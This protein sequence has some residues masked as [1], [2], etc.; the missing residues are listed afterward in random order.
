MADKIII[1]RTEFPDSI[2]IGTPGKFGNIKVY[3]DSSD[4][5]GS[6]TRVTNAVGIRAHFIDKLAEHGVIVSG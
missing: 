6:K 4:L 3:F 1:T 2:E 5:E